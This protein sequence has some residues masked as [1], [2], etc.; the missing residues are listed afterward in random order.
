VRAFLAVSPDDTL[1]EQVTAFQRRLEDVAAP[2]QAARISWTRPETVHLTFQFFPDLDERFAAPMRDAIESV[3]QAASSVRM[4]LS[5]LGAFPWP[6]APR[7]LWI[8]P[9]PEWEATGDGRKS[10]RLARAI[11]AACAGLGLAPEDKPWRPHLTL[12]RIKEGERA[13]GRAISEAGF[14]DRP[15][16]SDSLT[17]NAISLVRSDAG[18]AGHVHTTLWTAPLT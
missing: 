18:P 5:R 17:V 13:V 8:G 6:L 7:V 11:E 2:S 1:R 16:L 15:A 14:F 3:T 12:A 10:L 9:P 4:P